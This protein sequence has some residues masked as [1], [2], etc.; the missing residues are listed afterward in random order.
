MRTQDSRRLSRG[1]IT[2]ALAAAILGFVGSGLS[3]YD[4]IH[5]EKQRQDSE[6]RM[7]NLETKVDELQKQFAAGP[8]KPVEEPPP[9]ASQPEGTN[10]KKAAKPPDRAFP[11][12]SGT[13]GK[14]IMTTRTDDAA[15]KAEGEGDHDK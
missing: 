2:V 10:D 12:Q 5:S 14:K 1:F 13:P 3:I 6:Q 15:K 4:L 11:R 8:A 9:N 7:H